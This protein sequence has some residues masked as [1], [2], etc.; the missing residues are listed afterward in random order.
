MS[1][2]DRLSWPAGSSW[3]PWMVNTGSAM[4]WFGS[5]KLTRPEAKLAAGSERT[6]TATARSPRQRRE[7]I[8]MALTTVWREGLLSWKRSPPR[9]T[10]SARCCSAISKTSSKAANES[11][12]RTSSF[13]HTPC[14]GIRQRGAAGTGQGRRRVPASAQRNARRAGSLVG[15]SHQ[16]VVGGDHD[17]QDVGFVSHDCRWCLSYI[18]CSK[19]LAALRWAFVCFCLLKADRRTFRRSVA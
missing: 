10:R 18:L 4:L 6:C 8:S 12:R 9:R 14:G 13:S 5:W 16:M 19:T 11:W 3:L 15:P 17:S 7:R 1:T 2:A